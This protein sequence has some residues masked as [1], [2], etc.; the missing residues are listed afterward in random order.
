MEMVCETIRAA[1]EF[2][3][4]ER[5]VP[6]DEGHRIRLRVGLVLKETVDRTFTRVDSSR[7]VVLNQESVRFGLVEER[8]R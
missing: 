7:R 5:Y 4:G 2:T 8:Q 3:V 1:V 6:K